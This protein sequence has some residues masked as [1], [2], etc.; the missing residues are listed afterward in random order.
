MDKKSIDIL[1]NYF[2]Q[3]FILGEILF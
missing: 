1:S 3:I 2:D